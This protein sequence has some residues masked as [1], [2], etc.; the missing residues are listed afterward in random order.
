MTDEATDPG[1]GRL[2][3]PLYVHPAV[4]PAAWRALIHAGP[5]LYGVVLNIADGPGDTPDP[6]FVTAAAQLRE[7]GVRVLGYVDTAYGERS[8]RAVV[9][10]LR[11]H[12]R[13]Y[14]T[15]GAFLDRT[16]SAAGPLRHYRR[17][18]RAARVCGARTVVLNPGVHPA[19]GYADFADL[20]VTFEGTWKTYRHTDFTVPAWT[21]AHPPERFCHLVHGVPDGLCPLAARTARMRGAAVHC[22]VPGSGAN[23]WSGLPPTV[24]R[25]AS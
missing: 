11:R 16:A 21:G 2:L 19:P 23:P 18:T 24:E 14:D 3:V 22:A 4:D 10:D 15:D 20:L 7:A 5:Q 8:A 1:R 17:L 6:A 12:R 13:W 9:G 25:E